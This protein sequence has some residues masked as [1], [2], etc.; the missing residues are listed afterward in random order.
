[1]SSA[2]RA[3]CDLS[4]FQAENVFHLVGNF[5]EFAEATGGRVPFQGVHGA[6]DA[7]DE[8]LIG[9]LLLEMKAGVV[10]DLEQ[11]RGALKEESAEFGAAILGQEAQE[12]TSL[13][14]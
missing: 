10:D 5:T 11:F 2:R 4:D 7:A 6:A 12:F 14:W 3:P 9:G 1:M 13:R 8:L